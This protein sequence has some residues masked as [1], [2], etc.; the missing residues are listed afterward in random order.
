MKFLLP[1]DTRAEKR[2]MTK[3]I[4]NILNGHDNGMDSDFPSSRTKHNPS[5]LLLP[6]AGCQE[7]HT[8][9]ALLDLLLLCFSSTAWWLCELWLTHFRGLHLCLSVRF[10]DCSFCCQ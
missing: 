6:L 10:I 5:R 4:V 8:S 2:M 9:W 3:D 1:K 7:A